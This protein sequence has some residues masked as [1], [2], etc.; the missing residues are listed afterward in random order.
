MPPLHLEIQT[1]LISWNTSTGVAGGCVDIFRII[2]ISARKIG[3]G[4]DLD[5]FGCSILDNDAI[6]L[7]GNRGAAISS[8]K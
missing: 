7:F 1:S 6:D 8:L 5:R 2:C 3:H 4:G